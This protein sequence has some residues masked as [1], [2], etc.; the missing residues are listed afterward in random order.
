[1]QSLK[2]HN[3]LHVIGTLGLAGAEI[4]LIHYTK[5]LGSES[6]NHFVYCHGGDGPVK[7]RLENIGVKV[8]LGKKLASVLNP[9]KFLNSLLFIFIDIQLFIKKN[10][11]TTIHSHSEQSDILSLMVGKL[12]GIPVF[13]TIHNTRTSF[14]SR[15]RYDARKYIKIFVSYVMYKIADQIIAVS[16]EVKNEFYLRSKVK[17]SKIIVVQNGIYVEANCLKNSKKKFLKKTEKNFVV[18]SVG[19]LTYQKNFEVLIKAAGFLK[20]G[21]VE[22]L[23][24]KIAGKGPE[25]NKLSNLIKVFGIE[26]CFELLGL[27]EDVNNLMQN[28]DLFVMT[29]RYEGLSIAMIEAFSCGLPVVASDT[30]G[31]KSHI[32]NYKN[33]FLFPQGDY[34]AL[35]D[36][37]LKISQNKKLYTEISNGSLTSFKEKFDMKNNIRALTSIP[38]FREGK[39]KN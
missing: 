20:K 38:S 28:S 35:A 14:Q 6:Y 19:R 4:M 24:F 3:L 26:N 37:I 11:I 30:P 1:M 15:K 33:G 31:L 18:L 9:L 27:R 34:K 36:C 23:K 25:F 29:S 39:W 5:A 10:N 17:K 7:K 22:N 21:N 13:P 32:C 8:K 16:H 2:K 12:S